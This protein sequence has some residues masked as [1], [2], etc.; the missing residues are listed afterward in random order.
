[1]LFNSLNFLI[2][3]PI[4]F[5]LYWFVFKPLKW[6][7]LL[8]VVAS[9]VFYGW[10]DWRFLILI[11]I[12][13]FCSYLSGILLEK[14]EGKRKRQKAVSAVNIVLNLSILGI[15]KYYNFFTENIATLCQN[16]GYSL[17][18][19]TLDIILPVGISFYTFQA[20]SYT[21]DVYQHKIKATHDPVE[22]FAFISFFPQLVAGPIERATNLLPQFQ[23]ERHFDYAKAIDG[24][25]QMLWGFFKKMVVADSC[26]GC[27]N[28][29]WGSYSEQTGFVLWIGAL[30]F[31]F[32]IYCDFSGYSDIA[33]GTARLFGINLKRN[34]NVPYFSRNIPE[35]WRRWH[36]SLM[37]WFRDYIYFPLGGSR[38]AKWKV[39]RNT[40]IVFGVSGLWHGANWTFVAWGLYHA[41]LIALFI[42]LGINTKAKDVVA[43]GKVL[44]S[45]KETFQMLVTFLLAVIGWVI[46][47]AESI[48]QAIEYLKKMFSYSAFQ[49]AYFD[50]KR[51]LLFIFLMLIIEWVQRDKE[52]ALQFADNKFF[53]F[54]TIR[55][56][57][58]Y[59]LIV[60][61]IFFAGGNQTFIYFQF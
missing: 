36:I 27:A 29:I 19:V 57:A 56:T 13:S 43:S 10:W 45:L 55:W 5:L 24:C 58:Y 21:I 18:W 35:F 15:F 33:I 20:L 3:L 28:T 8:V 34:F 52:H 39:I 38:C 54:R 25:R 53:Q 47:R 50:G 23:K 60:A 26:A 2:F 4:V 31:T 11:A 30:F 9:Y 1:M 12:T 37:T 32:Q 7:N 14:H 44:P 40:L 17:D 59:L 49:Y 51:A 46:F 22:F 42:L 48:A 41:F 6:Q 61:I 16:F